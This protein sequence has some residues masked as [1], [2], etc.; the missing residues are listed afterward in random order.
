LEVVDDFN[1]VH[2][3]KSEL[4]AHHQSFLLAVC[5]KGMCRFTL[6]ALPDQINV[7]DGRCCD[8]RQPLC[9]VLL[10]L[11]VLLPLLH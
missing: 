5:R 4:L 11:V 10:L 2:S 1:R 7:A 9:S 8:N 6:F 3:V